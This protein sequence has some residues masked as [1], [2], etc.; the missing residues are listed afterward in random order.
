MNE[1]E[2]LKLKNFGYQ[3]YLTKKYA[4]F[5]KYGIIPMDDERPKQL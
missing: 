2:E 1:L 4:L 3:A 5:K